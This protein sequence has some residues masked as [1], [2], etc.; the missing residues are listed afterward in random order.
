M[1][2]EKNEEKPGVLPMSEKTRYAKTEQPEKKTGSRFHRNYFEG[3]KVV[4]VLSPNGKTHTKYVYALPWKKMDI[5]DGQFRFRKFL[6]PLLLCASAVLS[7]LALSKPTSVNLS[8]PVSVCIAASTG[9]LLYMFYLII[10][11][12]FLSRLTTIGDYKTCFVRLRIVSIASAACAFATAVAMVVLMLTTQ[13]ATSR[14]TIPHVLLQTLSAL[15]LGVI[16]LLEN[17][18]RYIDVPNDSFMQHEH[19]VTGSENESEDAPV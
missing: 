18:T 11:Y 13:D 12:C 8:M 17:R 14:Q 19:S 5:S 2:S 6:Y 7:Y 15:L 4:N 10:N 9:L 16:A 3:Y 1:E